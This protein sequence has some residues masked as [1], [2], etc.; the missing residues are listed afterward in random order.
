MFT[1]DDSSLHV[2]ATPAAAAHLQALAAARGNVTVVL[3]DAGAAVLKSGEQPRAGAVLLGHLDDAGDI[4][5]VA[6]NAG[7]HDWWR[8]RAQLDLSDD[9][10]MTYDLSTLSEAE[11]FAVLAAGPLPRY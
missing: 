4:T 2:T 11:L 9:L 7:A 10:D 5:C 6:D 1:V 8:S 3:S